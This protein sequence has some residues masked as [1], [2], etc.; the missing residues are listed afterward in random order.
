MRTCV[1]C[2][3]KGSNFKRARRINGKLSKGR[4]KV[5]KWKKITERTYM[6]K[7][8]IWQTPIDLMSSLLEIYI[9]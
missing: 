1:G 7:K 8:S 4:E 5:I 9:K 6:K 2:F 3:Y